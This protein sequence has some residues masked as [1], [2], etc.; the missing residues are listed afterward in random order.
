MN[1]NIERFGIDVAKSKLDVALL[2]E[3]GKVKSH[4]VSND[5]KGRAAGALWPD[6]ATRALGGADA[7]AARALR[8]GRSAVE[9]EGDASARSQPARSGDKP[10]RHAS[11][12]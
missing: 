1:E 2:D 11:V 4:V 10:G 7:G 5:A 12:H 6:D 8:A 3:R 9:L